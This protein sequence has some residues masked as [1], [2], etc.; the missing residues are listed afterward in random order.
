MKI[1][2]P[3]KIKGVTLVELMIS[4]VL[5]VVLSSA[6]IQA[7]LTTKQLF[8]KQNAIARIQE[9]ARVI[10][11]VLGEAIEA[12]GSLGCTTFA[13]EHSIAIANNI[14]AQEMLLL[15]RSRVLGIAQESILPQLILA[16]ISPQSNL[17]AIKSVDKLQPVISIDPKQNMVTIKGKFDYE[18]DKIM[19]ISDCAHSVFAKAKAVSHQKGKTFISFASLTNEL[20]QLSFSKNITIGELASQ[21]YYIG[22]THRVNSNGQQVDALYMSDFNGRTLELVEGV[23]Q[24]K[25]L[26]GVSDGNKIHYVTQENVSDWLAI[27]KVRVSLLLTSIEDTLV[28]NKQPDSVDNLLKQWWHFEWTIK[29]S[30]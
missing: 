4:L 1:A 21:L 5:G 17:V 23:E 20:E 14:N 8:I 28:I 6:C 27:V 10:A 26:Y 16:R 18:K 19:V 29:G 2:L 25:I 7:F 12:S 11:I 30:A 3:P 15:P 9:N 22:N 13:Q 24:M